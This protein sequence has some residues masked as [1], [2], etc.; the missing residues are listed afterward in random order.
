MGMNSEADF[1]KALTKYVEA[2]GG[3]VSN[4]ESHLSSAGIPDMH[5]FLRPHDFWLELKAVGS[6]AQVKMRPT[7][8]KWHKDRYAAGGTS[9][10]AVLIIGTGDI[11][12]VPGHVAAGLDTRLDSWRAV[13]ETQNTLNKLIQRMV[14]H[15]RNQEPGPDCNGAPE[16]PREPYD[17][18]PPGG[19][20]VGSHHWLLD[21]P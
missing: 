11:L 3:H 20:D 14:H 19:A 8:R 13:A 2:I 7:Q 21:K 4:I 12:L 15:V 5:F 16:G 17:S 9:F 18:F 6:R 1:R 10:V